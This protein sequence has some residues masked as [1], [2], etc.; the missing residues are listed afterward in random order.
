MLAQ[1]IARLVLE[2]GR[3]V[4]VASARRNHLQTLQELLPPSIQT[5]LCVGES[6]KKAKAHRDTHA[7][8]WDVV[9]TTFR[10][11]EEGLD[12]PHLNT[13]VIASPKKPSNSSWDGSRGGQPT[14]GPRVRRVRQPC[15]HVCG[16]APKRC[17][18][19]ARMAT[20]CAFMRTNLFLSGTTPKK[21]L[22]PI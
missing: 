20:V 2:Q 22:D 10:M 18:H 6:S 7:A 1:M 4:L 14:G 8:D 16:H 3:K 21:N 9:L 11:G 17:A 5:G 12:L 19:Y 13:L 15:V